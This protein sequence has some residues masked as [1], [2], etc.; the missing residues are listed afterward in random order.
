MNAWVCAV[1][2]TLAYH[3]RRVA[4]HMPSRARS[5]PLSSEFGKSK[6]VGARSM[7]PLP[8]GEPRHFSVRCRAKM[9]HSER[10]YYF[11]DFYL[12]AKTLWTFTWKYFMDFRLK[13]LMV[14]YLEAN[15]RIWS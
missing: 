8:S 11:V 10:F 7:S 15:A 13:G 5:L 3:L 9:E 1:G 12:E 2:F 4:C 14:F 6:T